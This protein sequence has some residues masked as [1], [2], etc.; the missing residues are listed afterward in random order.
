M[1]MQD[2]LINTADLQRERF[3]E[4]PE[5]KAHWERTALARAVAVEV[6]R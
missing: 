1:L 3:R 4:N 2:R 6:I 5:A